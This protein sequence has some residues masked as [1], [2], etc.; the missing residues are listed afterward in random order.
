MDDLLLAGIILFIFTVAF[1]FSMGLCGLLYRG[2]QVPAPLRLLAA[3]L[4]NFRGGVPSL[5]PLFMRTLRKEL[6]AAYTV[7]P[8]GTRIASRA[9]TVSIS[10]EDSAE[11]D[12]EGVLERLPVL[13]GEAYG[14]IASRAG[15]IEVLPAMSVWI[16]E[17]YACHPN[18]PRARTGRPSLRDE[19]APHIVSTGF[20]PPDNQTEQQ[21]DPDSPRSCVMASSMVVAQDATTP[22]P[23]KAPAE[24]VHGPAYPAVTEV[25]AGEDDSTE[26]DA[27]G[28]SQELAL[29]VRE[30]MI[31]CRIT[32]AGIKIG[33]NDDNDLVIR[34]RSV[35][36]RHAELK[37][38]DGQLV[39]EPIEGRTCWVNGVCVSGPSMVQLGDMLRFSRSPVAFYVEA[40][41]G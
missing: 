31:E 28:T 1:V 33:R 34:D 13:V 20:A 37:H 30:G 22:M 38:I 27:T 23:P 26:P 12:R 14:M 2:L 11:L 15:W 3:M 16:I 4:E 32:A 40:G 36:R 8:L 41:R 6:C 29:L 19:G 39:L 7:T 24:A 17:D 10:P 25:R 18:R 35:S 9:L 5:L 21:D